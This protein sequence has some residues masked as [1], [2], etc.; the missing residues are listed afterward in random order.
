M[1]TIER[2]NTG[3]S[4]LNR[5]RKEINAAN[6]STAKNSL[7]LRLHFLNRVQVRTVGRQIEQFHILAFQGLPNSLY[8]MGTHIVH[9]NNIT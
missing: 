3:N 5:I 2:G 1:L 9:Y 4:S 8:M 6:F 7:G